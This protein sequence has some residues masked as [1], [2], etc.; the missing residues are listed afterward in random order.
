MREHYTHTFGPPLERFVAL[1]VGYRHAGAPPSIHVGMPSG[2][3]TLVVPF[4]EPLVLSGGELTQPQPFDGVLAGLAT[5]PTLIHHDGRQHGLQLSLTPTGA[6]AV[7]GLPAAE[8]AERS[9]ELEDVAGRVARSLREDLEG[10]ATWPLR[11]A[12]IERVLRGLMRR[13]ESRRE[14]APEVGEAWRLIRRGRGLT[15]V[16]GVA[17]AVGWSTRHLEQRFRAE[18]GITPKSAARVTRFE[19]SVEAAR[20]PRRRLADIAAECGYADQAHLAREW[21]DLAGLPPSRWRVE[22]HLAFV[23]DDAAAV[24]AGSTT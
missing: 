16:G 22:D 8:L 23:Q 13:H 17:S 2:A 7:F 4:D 18:F 5:G 15:P 19:R 12:A 20:S 14:A 1:A 3:L 24:S 9:V 6:R 10:Y 11:F 21:R